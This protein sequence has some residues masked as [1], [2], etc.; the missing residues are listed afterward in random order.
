MRYA[1]LFSPLTIRSVTFPNRVLSTGHQTYLARDGAVG[2]DLIAY[3]AARAKGGAGAIIVEAARFHGSALTDAPELR[4]TTD[5]C[6][7]GYRRLA[8]AVH[9]AGAR[10]MGQLSHAGRCSAGRRRGVRGVVYAPSAVPE[11]RF[12]TMPREMPTD[13]VAEIVAACGAAAGRLAAAG[14]DGVELMASHGLLFAQFL[15][16]EVNRRTDRYGGTPENRLRAL[17]EALAAARAAM[18]EERLVGLRISAEEL[19]PGGLER[20]QVARIVRALAERGLIDYVNTTTGS[21]AGLGGSVH[22]VPPMEIAPGYLAPQA[23]ALKEAS[24]LPVFVAGRINQPQ[25]AERILAAGQAD[26]CGMTR[27]M[28]ADP[29]MAG[30]ARAGRAEEITACIGCNQA[31]IGHFHQGAPIS[32]IQTPTTGRELRFGPVAPAATSRRVLVAGG[33]P[34]GMKAAVTA[35]ERGHDVTLFEEGARLGGQALLAQLL[36][37]RAEFG[38]LVTNLTGQLGRLGVAV[39]LNT[40]L[41]RAMVEEERPDLVILATGARAHRMPVEG[42]QDGHVLDAWQLLRDEAEPGARVLVADWRCDWVGPGVAEKLALAGRRVRLA[43]NGLHMG[44]ELQPYLRDHW[45]GKLHR[46]GVEVIPYAQIF[47]VDADT[48]WLRHAVT[49]APIVCEGVDT[50]VLAHG[51]VART[52]LEEALRGSG[53]A[54]AL[55]GDCLGPRSAEEAIYEGFIAGLNA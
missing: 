35:A 47:G 6:I 3:H 18:G 39:R 52:K 5:D 45:A 23:G 43:V 24:G 11:N 28:I 44:Q 16:P 53:I 54:T 13:M 19:E 40:A 33:G 14:L 29:S 46:L 31:C 17:A 32:C 12:H 8:D 25:E 4:A 2:D 49:G 9:A 10:I 15:N 48:V 36:P 21:M 26:M 34:A 41:D 22:V 50:V 20:E 1:H 27:A 51:G 30:K 42:A 55:A 37:E 7:D 38:G